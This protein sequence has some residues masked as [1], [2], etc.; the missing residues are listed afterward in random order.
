MLQNYLFHRRT[1]NKDI[2]EGVTV[3]EGTVKTFI[4]F[5][6]I[7]LRTIGR[8]VIETKKSTVQLYPSNKS[9]PH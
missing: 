7:N 1:Q 5:L 6:L 3:S 8:Q 9:H 4:R 2:F